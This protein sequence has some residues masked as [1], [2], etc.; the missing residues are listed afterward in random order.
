M[1]CYQ[2]LARDLGRS[3]FS[4]QG[5]G[6]AL[7]GRHRGGRQSKATGDVSSRRRFLKGR[8][9]EIL[10]VKR[11]PLMKLTG[12]GRTRGGGATWM[13][14]TSHGSSICT[15]IQNRFV[16]ARRMGNK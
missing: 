7:R 8:C 6:R 14:I 12:D 3:L 5:A 13:R 10:E 11:H 2:M 16:V 15:H 1:L 4:D 9:C